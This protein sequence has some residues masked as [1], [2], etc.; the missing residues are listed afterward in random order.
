MKKVKKFVHDRLV[1]FRLLSHKG[2]AADKAWQDSK[3]YDDYLEIQ[4]RRTLAKKDAGPQPRTGQLIERVAKDA[5]LLISS[6]V[7]VTGF[8]KEKVAAPPAIIMCFG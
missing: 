6:D 3:D 7:I 2:E 1:D 8:P 5:I 4:L